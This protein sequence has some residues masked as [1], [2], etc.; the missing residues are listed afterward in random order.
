M[1]RNVFSGLGEVVWIAKL[2]AKILSYGRGSKHNKTVIIVTLS[3][4][5]V[6]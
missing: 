3:T 6:S 1:S 5:T 2:I 4:A